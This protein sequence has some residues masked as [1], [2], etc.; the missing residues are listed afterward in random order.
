MKGLRIGLCQRPEH[1]DFADIVY[2]SEQPPLYIHFQFGP[3]RE[4]VHALLDTDVGKHRLDNTQPSG[5]DP[6]A[7]FSI[8]LGFHLFDQIGMQT[9][10]LNG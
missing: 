7:L 9:T 4:A 8:D 1:V 3:Q 2:Q 10:H 6:L 5:V